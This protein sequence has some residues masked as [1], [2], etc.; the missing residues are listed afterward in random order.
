MVRQRAAGRTDPDIPMLSARFPRPGSPDRPARSPRGTFR[1]LPAALVLVTLLPGLV[2]YT[3]AAQDSEPAARPIG[4]GVRLLQWTRAAGPHAL[5]AVEVDLSDALVRLGVSLGG[6]E[7]LALDPLSRQA[8][9]LTRP[10]RYP[11]AGVNGDFFYYPDSRQPGIPTNAAVVD[12]ELVRTPFSRS[13]LVLDGEGAPS[14]RLLGFR[15]Q[16]SGPGGAARAL[17][18]VN[19]PRGASQ[20]VLYTPRFGAGTRTGADGVEVFLAPE[21]F[22]L[23]HG[24]THRAIVQAVQ[25]GAGGAALNPGTWVLSGS[26]TAGA[27]LRGLAPQDAVELRAEFDP[28]LGPADQVLGGGPRLLREGRI[29]IE[30]EG[31]SLGEGFARARHPRS[32]IGFRGRKVYLLAVDGRQ[33]GYSLGMSLPEVAQ[34]LLDLGCTEGMN[35]DGGGSTTLWARGAVVNRP[36]DGRERPVANGLLV[37]STAPKGE[38][39]RLVPAP[40]EIAALAGAEV[41][42]A[43]QGEDR[44]YNPVSL[45]G[46]AAQWEA[47]PP[48]GMVKDG[49]FVAAAAPEPPG[50]ADHVAGTLRV[51]LGGVSGTLPVRVYPRPARL[52][53]LPASARAGTRARVTFRLRAFDAQGRPLLLPSTAAWEADPA[54]G[55]MEAGGILAT[56]EQAGQGSVRVSLGGVTATAAVEV[57]E[58][59]ARALEDF[60]SAQRAPGDWKLQ[61]TPPGTVGAVEVAE[62]RAH[63]GR[64]A[65]RLQYDFSTGSG[66]RAVY[67]LGSRDLGTPFALRA[68]VYGDGQGAWLRL[69]VRDRNRRAYVLDLARRVDWKNEWREL[70][71][72]FSDDLPGPLT[73]EAL[74]LVEPDAALKPRGAVLIDDVTV[75]Q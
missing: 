39:V 74:Y 19:Q 53:L 27:F 63:S 46:A 25:A 56:G 1:L 23:R 48:L 15:G 62:G 65:L 64:R 61:V 7:K 33:P 22:P 71:V 40:A 21:R 42:L 59:A 60:E 50:G 45:P 9:R 32:A 11:I 18:A 24:E 75:E 37:F 73:L 3:R 2:R 41:P 35:L 34:A 67:A 55:T 44:Y 54:L 52:E 58:G 14:I 12:G 38:P 69:R 72:P 26:G 5:H 43:V 6:G 16:V 8:E 30:A 29:S 68:W 20:L 31:G 4:P 36:S 70:R 66:T 13:C 28:P 10:E 51:S 17:D 57:A 49:R 47:E